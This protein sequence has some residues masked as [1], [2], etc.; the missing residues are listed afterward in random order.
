M[1]AIFYYG[2]NG[3]FKGSV[4][5]AAAPA[6]ISVFDKLVGKDNLCIIT[7]IGITMTE[8]T[9]FFQ[10]FDDLIH[11]FWFGKGLGNISI[12]G[13]L[14]MDCHGK[15]PGLDPLFKAIGQQRGKLITC[16]M[17]SI[18]FKGVIQ[19]CNVTMVSEPETMVSFSISLA[20]TENSLPPAKAVKPRC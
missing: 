5:S 3:V 11:Y 16:T 1:A 18:L 17:G 7:Q 14:F 13:M 9:Q 20:M 6:N 4:G 8:T 10:T 15:M 19:E 12:Q 2:N